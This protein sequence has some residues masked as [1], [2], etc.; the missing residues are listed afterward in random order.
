MGNAVPVN[1][2][3]LGLHAGERRITVAYHEEQTKEEH[4]P[5]TGDRSV[6]SSYVQQNHGYSKSQQW[7][8][9]QQATLCFGG[10]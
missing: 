10:M 9:R 4:D 7:S 8:S 1:R 3:K 5:K 2:M 6:C